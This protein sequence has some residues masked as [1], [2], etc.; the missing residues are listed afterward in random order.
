[1]YGSNDKWDGL[2]LFLI[3]EADGSGTLRGHLNDRTTSYAKLESAGASPFALNR[4]FAKTDAEKNSFGKC[5]FAYR[6]LGTI[7]SIKVSYNPSS[8]KVTHDDQLCF[9]NEHI[10]LP[11]GHFF[12]VSASSSELPD[13]HELFGAAITSTSHLAAPAQQD[14]QQERERIPL[15]TTKEAPA[16][17]DTAMQKV[18]TKLIAD[19]DKM[20]SRIE[21]IVQLRSVVEKMA[22]SL[23]GL[24]NTMRAMHEG[25]PVTD[26]TF[27]SKA[28]HEQLTREIRGME[29]KFIQMEKHIE[30]QTD[31]IVASLP[32]VAGPLKNAVYAI[33]FVQ[34]VLCGVGIAL[35]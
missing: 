35:F 17:L 19:S 4:L 24:E 15:K 20:S 34:V 33:I 18:I 2:G 28:M 16:A 3:A 13:S 30:K 31:H 23:S 29:A 22:V 21:D 26:P 7:S 12:G 5:S 8:L 9:E 11:P 1:M 32:P 6:N 14:K 10:A 27:S 25:A